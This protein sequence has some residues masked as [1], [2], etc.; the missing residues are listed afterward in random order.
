ML[1][2]GSLT[3]ADLVIRTIPVEPPPWPYHISVC[4]RW[5]SLAIRLLRVSFLRTLGQRYLALEIESTRI[6]AFWGPEL[7]RG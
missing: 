3:F 5:A 4:R 2:G 6:A 1:P 7:R